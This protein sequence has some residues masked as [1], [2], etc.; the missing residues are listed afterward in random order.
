MGTR[1]LTCVVHNDEIKVAQ[2]GQ[3][4]GYPDGQ[5]QTIVDF[6]TAKAL[7]LDD[8]KQRVSNLGTVDDDFI[9]DM[10]LKYG[11]EEVG[12]DGALSIDY[13]KGQVMSR[14]NPAFSRDTGADILALIATGKA[15]RVELQTDF[16]AD[17]LFCEFA[18]VL[19]LDRDV[20]EFYRGFQTEPHSNGRFADME[21]E[22]GY[23]SMQYYP[24]RLQ[25]NR[26]RPQCSRQENE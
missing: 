12:G 15:E 2:Y 6:L 14:E 20:L 3:W 16:A 26:R 11:A 10:W 19:D 8:F 4:D 7:D 9:K 22:K 25:R 21:F 23:R 18:Y 24:V 1:N 13:E 5:G 17:S